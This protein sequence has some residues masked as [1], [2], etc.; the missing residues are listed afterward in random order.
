MS[1]KRKPIE[2]PAILE[3]TL[4]FPGQ[5]EEGDNYRKHNTSVILDV[6]QC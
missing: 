1:G 6:R 5:G 2:I 4:E 3:L